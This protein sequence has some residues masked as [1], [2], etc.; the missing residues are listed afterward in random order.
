MGRPCCIK[1]IAKIIKVGKYEASI[2][3]LE[4]AFENVYISG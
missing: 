4:V 3:G 1:P 2:T